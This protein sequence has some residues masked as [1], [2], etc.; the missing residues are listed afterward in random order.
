M[1]PK[2]KE[3]EASVVKLTLSTGLILAIAGVIMSGCGSGDQADGTSGDIEPI[4]IEELKALL[5][6][7]ADVV[8]VDVRSRSLYDSGHIPG[9]ISMTYPDEIQSRHQELP[10]DRTLILY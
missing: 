9:A 1:L 7:Q 4:Y 6:T 3:W 2:N 5:D 10:T 8:V